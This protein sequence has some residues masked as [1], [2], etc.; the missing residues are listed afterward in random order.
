M[1]GWQLLENTGLSGMRKGVLS[2][3]R[4]QLLALSL[5]SIV[6]VMFTSASALAGGG[7]KNVL[8]VVNEN[9]PISQAVAEY[10][11]IK[12][13]IPERNICRINCTAN[14]WI[15]KAECEAQIVAPIRNFLEASGVHDRIDYIV[16]TKGIPL[17]ASYY[18]SGWNGEVSVAS[19]LT[20]IDVPSITSPCNN[21]YG[22]TAYPPAP[23]QYFSHQLSFSGKS[24]YIVTRL[25]G[26]NLEQIF[27]MIDDSVSAV[28]CNGM[29]LLDGRYE[30]DPSSAFY[31]ANNRLR[32]A[33][34]NLSAAG[35]STYY[36]ESDFDLFINEFVGNQQGLM[37]YFS[38]GSNEFVSYTLAA[39]TSNYF[40]PGS[41]AD[42]F[43]STSARTFTYPPS[44]GQSLVA[45]LIPQ[46]VCA[47]NG[48]VS[49]PD[50]RYATYPDV[51]FSRYTQGY[52]MGESFFAATPR[53][54]WKA[55][56][57]GDPLMAPY[58]T[59]PNVT[60]TSPN[61]ELPLHGTI[62]ISASAS[63]ES[64]ISKV[65]FYIDDVLIATCNQAPFEFLWDTTRESDGTHVI[66]A[67]AYENS[68]VFTQGMASLQV[69][70]SNTP[71]DVVRV[72][73]VRNLPDGT[74]V[75][76][77]SKPVIAGCDVFT[78]CIYVCEPDRSASVRVE[79][80]NGLTTGSL[81]TVWG[82]LVTKN[83]EKVITRASGVVEGST[84]LPPPFA[85]PNVWVANMRATSRNESNELLPGLPNTGLLVKTWG[86]VT[87][88]EANGFYICDE[89]RNWMGIDGRIKVSLQDLVKSV[90]LPAQDSYV[91]VV[92]VSCY[93]EEGGV[94]KPAIRPRMPSDISIMTPSII[95]I[96][97]QANTR[98]WNLIS[99]P[100]IL[101]Y[102]RMSQLFLGVDIDG[103][104]LFMDP[105]QRSLLTY[106][107]NNP[108]H[109][110]PFSP[111]LAFW[112][113]SSKT[114]QLK[115]AAMINE[116]NYDFWISIPSAVAT[117]FGNP[118]QR[119]VNLQ[120]CLVS[121]GSE[122][123]TIS[124]A[125]NKGWIFQ[126]LYSWN[127]IS[128]SLEEVDIADPNAS[129][130]PW[131]GYWLLPKKQNLALIIP[132]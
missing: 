43:V 65:E 75:R 88:V 70:V 92:G 51:L 17:K 131:R 124:A 100:G 9:S 106:D 120:E 64:G 127:N 61:S 114:T 123:V 31:K 21:P 90:P 77:A 96:A 91:G 83:S 66:E 118:F 57:V 102:P 53:L 78:D 18:D 13:G 121:D 35:F 63:D 5:L 84:A 73:D 32:Q 80:T 87:Q 122:T 67:I 59:P 39:Y 116:P 62:V 22:P 29:F 110:P 111:G 126:V 74:L 128:K 4:R 33:N 69:Q 132:H 68:P 41:I 2:G 130:E 56:T 50:I 109:F 93:Y 11:K 16:L 24:Y 129:L 19:I 36:N 108:S 40:V 47:V 81:A 107:A 37:G 48:Y 44:V 103:K 23:I 60:I 117:I 113:Y 58:A 42:T 55:V 97:E 38:W 86:Y 82:E 34:R 105:I 49:E 14:E 104:V 76:L 3:M 6:G 45:D 119:Q 7:P 95:T 12:R 112:F 79:G 94:L 20:C 99:I 26:Y 125:A 115:T 98:G 30:S 54:Y 72:S 46:G 52:N 85:T 27:R 10:Y 1:F 89:S 25:D 101:P 15:S 28:G 71:V 8:L